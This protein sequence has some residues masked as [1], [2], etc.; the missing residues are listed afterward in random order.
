MAGAA[1][2]KHKTR[3]PVADQRIN[4]QSMPPKPVGILTAAQ[5]RPSQRARFGIGQQASALVGIVNGVQIG[6][7][8]AEKCFQPNRP[9]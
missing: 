2:V 6:H 5:Q 7:E 8:R 9:W 4:Q 1:A 3:H